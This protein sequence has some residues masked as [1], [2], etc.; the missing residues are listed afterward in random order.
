MSASEIE[1]AMDMQNSVR[2]GAVTDQ[3]MLGESPLR[4]ITILL[5]VTQLTNG[6]T[7]YTFGPFQGE[8]RPMERP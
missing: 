6:N 3:V 1:E 4:T 2:T 8:S 7:Q 5:G